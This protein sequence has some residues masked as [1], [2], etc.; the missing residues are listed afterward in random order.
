MAE[1]Q[2]DAR[3][4]R[5]RVSRGALARFLLL[6][7]ALAAGF[8]A[9]RYSPLSGYMTEEAMTGLFARLAES[10]WAPVALVLSYVVLCPLGVPAT[11]MLLAGG[12]V[13]GIALGTLYNFIGTL[14]AAAATYFL[15][16]KL[17]RDFV[18]QLAGARL[19]RVE[20][21]LARRG[22]WSLVGL[23]MVPLPFALINY[24]AALAGVR[25]ILYLT[26][27]TLGLFPAVCLFTYFA[28]A[29]ARAAGPE[30]RGVLLQLTLA[31]LLLAT[32]IFIPRFAVAWKRRKR[33]REIVARRRG[34]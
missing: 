9:L 20:R 1:P 24:G 18:A 4:R 14:S 21:Q 27:S 8:L 19:K 26:T 10:W 23:R 30:R 6:P 25:P 33:Y 12:A 28:D 22:F 7:L 16:R 11:P 32:L 15:G 17:G 2:D 13:F 29:L 31:L 3:E 5:P 34:R